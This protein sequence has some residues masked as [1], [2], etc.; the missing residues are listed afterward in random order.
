MVA[1][2]HR[3]GTH[4]V[5]IPHEYKNADLIDQG[6]EAHLKINFIPNV[7]GYTDSEGK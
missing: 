1:E 2:G 6:T 4:Y 3:V 7:A 5:E